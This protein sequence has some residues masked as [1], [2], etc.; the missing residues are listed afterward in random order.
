MEMC[1]GVP[2]SHFRQEKN[3][4]TPPKLQEKK[5]RDPPKLQGK[6]HF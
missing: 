4:R 5:S 1:P 2:D 6:N 3:L